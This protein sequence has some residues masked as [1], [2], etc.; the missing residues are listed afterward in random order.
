MAMVDDVLL[1]C[2]LPPPLRFNNISISIK[3]LGQRE[4]P[5]VE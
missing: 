4:G 3:T 5:A 2:R 1:A